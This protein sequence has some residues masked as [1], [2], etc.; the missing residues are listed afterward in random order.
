MALVALLTACLAASSST[1]TLPA[2]LV[3]QLATSGPATAG[4]ATATAPLLT[5]GPDAATRPAL[6]TAGATITPRPTAA[7]SR[8]PATPCGGAACVAAATH[9][10]LARPIPPQPELVNYVDRSYPYGST[11]AGQREPHHG[12]EFFNRS[13]APVLAAAAGV[14]VSAGPDDTVALGPATR[15]YGNVVVVRHDAD[16]AGQPVYSLYGHLSSIAVAIDQHVAAGEPLGAVGSTGVAIGP[17]LHFEVRVGQNDYAST[18]NPELWLTPLPLNGK[19]QGVIAGRVVDTAGNVLTEVTVVIRPIATDAEHPRARYPQTY[20]GDTGLNGDDRL[21][22]NFAI[23]DL[24]PGTYS[25]SVNTTRLYQQTVT[26]SPGQVTW[27]TFRVNPPP[28]GSTATE[29]TAAATSLA[30]AEVTLDPTAIALTEA[31]A[32]PTETPQPATDVPPSEPP[33]EPPTAVP[34]D[35]PPVATTGP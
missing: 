34:S 1:S 28:P 20:A 18:R 16:Y 13:G 6:P 24:P 2:P 27:V 23:G 12:V 3:V 22:E 31:A 14:V 25:V 5:T 7:A 26:V 35:S 30:T 21:K 15:F 17:H 10:W 4:P 19:P 29:A 32:T 8:V 11:Q 9:L 33:T